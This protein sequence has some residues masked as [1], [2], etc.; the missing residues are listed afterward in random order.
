MGA[1]TKATSF[2]FE[3]LEILAC[4]ELMMHDD[5]EKIK[6]LFQTD[7]V[8]QGQ[9]SS[10]RTEVDRTD[11]TVSGS[12]DVDKVYA[13]DNLYTCRWYHRLPSGVSNLSTS[14]GMN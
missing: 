2:A 5:D 1:I 7:P 6:F 14:F 12:C 4:P 8:Q 13:S 3:A 9:I 10:C 11:W